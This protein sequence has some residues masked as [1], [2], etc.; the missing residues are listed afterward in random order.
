[1]TSIDT[2]APLA[3]IQDVHRAAHSIRRHLEHEVLAPLR[4]RITTGIPAEV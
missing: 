2:V 4:A 3:A 1:M